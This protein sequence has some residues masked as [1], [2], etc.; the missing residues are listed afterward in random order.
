MIKN[1][2]KSLIRKRRELECFSVINRGVLWYDRL[3]I[4]QLN[5][6]ESWYQKWLDAPETGIVP[7]AP[8]WINDTL[9]TKETEEILL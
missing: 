5:E 8:T 3:T 7:P 4:V 9:N 1:N 2:S 6:L